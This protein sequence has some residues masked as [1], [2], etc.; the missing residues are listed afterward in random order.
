MQ[1]ITKE[2]IAEIT[3]YADTLTLGIALAV[4]TDKPAI[5]KYF[6]SEVANA[7]A[8]LAYH[9]PKPTAPRCPHWNCIKRA[10]AIMR[11]AG[12]NSKADAAMRAAFS[13]YLGREVES[14]DT[15]SG[16]EWLLLG[17]AIKGNRLAW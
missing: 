17:D 3:E 2:L 6:R 15:L 9:A 8:F 4:E 5:E 13:R 14:R 12:L 7:R 1:N 16:G 11:E 10:Y